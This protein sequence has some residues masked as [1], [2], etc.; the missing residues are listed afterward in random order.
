MLSDEDIEEFSTSMEDDSQS[1]YECNDGSK[2]RAQCNIV[3]NSIRKAA[4]KRSP[5]QT[6]DPNYAPSNICGNEGMIFVFSTT[7]VKVMASNQ[8]GHSRRVL[9]WMHASH[10]E[11]GPLILTPH[12]MSWF[13]PFQWTMKEDST[14]KGWSCVQMRKLSTAIKSVNINY[15]LTLF[16][17]TANAGMLHMD[18][19]MN[20]I[21]LDNKQEKYMFIDWEEGRI[22]AKRKNKKYDCLFCLFAEF[23]MIRLVIMK[24]Y[25]SD[26]LIKQELQKIASQKAVVIEKNQDLFFDFILTTRCF[27]DNYLRDVDFEEDTIRTFF[28]V[29]GIK[30][31]IPTPEWCDAHEFENGIFGCATQV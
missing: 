22:F 5:L 2:L 18:P 10:N 31:L 30:Q 16:E 19:S 4:K 11:I 29:L 14:Y 17:T 9:L 23:I 24:L 12:E 13:V 28:Q 27:S 20:N 6:L 1:C 21:M 26:N 15:L 25:T 7:V 8:E 3:Q